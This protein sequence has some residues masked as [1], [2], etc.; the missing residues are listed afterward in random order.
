MYNNIL[1]AYDFDNSFHNVPKELANLT[2]NNTQ[3]T[4][5]I[6]NVIP[7]IDL[8]K[9]VRYDNKHYEELV[10]EKADQL[11]PFVKELEDIG[12][13]VNIRFTAGSIKQGILKEIED[14]GYDIIVMSNKRPKPG[15]K[16]VLGNV[17][18]KIANAAP[19][20]VLIIK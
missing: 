2:A 3:A 5:T 18:H 11:R 13:E 16:D 1:L 12:L 14:N 15:L 20:P 19:S 17:T 8:Q 9:S 4:V 6:L 7:E 10:E